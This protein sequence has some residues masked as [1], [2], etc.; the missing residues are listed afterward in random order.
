MLIRLKRWILCFVV[1]AALLAV[2]VTPRFWSAPRPANVPYGVICL[3]DTNLVGTQDFA[4]HINYLRQIWHKSVAHPYRLAEQERIVRTWQPL[5][6]MGFPHAY[7]PVALATALPLL[8][9][10][11]PWAFALFTF[12]NAALLILLTYRYLLPRIKN[13]VQGGAVLAT[14]CS[15]ALFDTFNM[16]QTSITTTC[17]LAAGYV[18]FKN[19]LCFDAISFSGHFSSSSV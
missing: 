12:F 19:A 10:P 2:W 11:V 5:A 3:P 17:I 9:I 4:Y 18:F 8:A 15:Y 1:V 7:S 13:L 6:S 14:F 16:G